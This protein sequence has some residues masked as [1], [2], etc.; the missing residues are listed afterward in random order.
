MIRRPVILIVAFAAVSA[1]QGSTFTLGSISLGASVASACCPVRPYDGGWEPQPVPGTDP[2]LDVS[3]VST[4][5]AWAVG[6]GSGDVSRRALLER[7]EEDTGW[8]FVFK[9]SMSSDNEF[10][11][12]DALSGNNVWAVGYKKA[13]GTA[14][15]YIVHYNGV[16]FERIASPSAAGNNF[17]ESISLDSAGDGWAVGYHTR[18][19]T[20]APLVEHWDGVSWSMVSTPHVDDARLLSVVTISPSNAW[21]VGFVSS[22]RTQAPLTE[23]WDGTDWSVVGTPDV[24][25]SKLLGVTAASADDVWASGSRA[26]SNGRKTLIEH[27]DGSAWSVQATPDPGNDPILLDVSA[28]DP[29]SA[30]AVGYYIDN[31]GNDVV[32]VE[33]W[34]G[35]TWSVDAGAPSPGTTSYQD[36]VSAVSATD[37]WTVGFRL[38]VTTRRA[39]TERRC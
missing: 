33:H 26:T 2:L 35:S 27:W 16:T 24:G 4:H 25:D 32:L 12:V 14:Q 37:V 22:G 19:A 39:L 8:I 6:G 28:A 10:F 30:W 17:L 7:F 34:D 36:A 38:H 13:S 1:F 15:T 31:S 9:G 20:D 29:E 21:A 5:D 11:G 23:H 3:A 18:S